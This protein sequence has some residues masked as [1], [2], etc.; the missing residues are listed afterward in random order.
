V[1]VC[2]PSPGVGKS[3]LSVNLA[4]VLGASGKRVLLVDGDLRRGRLHRYLGEKRAPGVCEV[5][6]GQCSFADA[7][8][9]TT[10][11]NVDFIATGKL[12]PNPAE[13]VGSSRFKAFVSDVAS[14]YELVL[15]DTPPIL[16]VTDGAVIGRQ[17]GVNLLAL[18]S[19]RH[20]IREIALAVKHFVDSGVPVHGAVVNAVKSEGGRFSR[21][22]Q[23][24]YQYAYRTDSSET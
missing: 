3:F 19:G 17:A 12:P 22:N 5:V 14:R 16:A 8:R 1:T 13:L 11:P 9:K 10:N 7:T 2:G 20:P 23:Y 15:I 21:A 18:R 4:F 24:H 6:S